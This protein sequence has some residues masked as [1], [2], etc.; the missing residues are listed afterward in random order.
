MYKIPNSR[1]IN[2]AIVILFFSPVRLSLSAKMILWLNK[3]LTFYLHVFVMYKQ[4]KNFIE[5]SKS[6]SI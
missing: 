1:K 2:N 3:K 4:K 5:A 6:F